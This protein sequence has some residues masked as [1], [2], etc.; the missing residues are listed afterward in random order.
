MTQERLIQ[1]ILKECQIAEKLSNLPNRQVE[2]R[3]TISCIEHF[4]RKAL[5][6]SNE[7]G[8]VRPAIIKK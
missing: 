1:A 6:F 2:L 4:A 7:N 8:G 5:E 3:A